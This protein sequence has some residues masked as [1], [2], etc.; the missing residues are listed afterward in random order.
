M[1]FNVHPEELENTELKA[2]A[3]FVPFPLKE[4]LERLCNFKS[5]ADLE[6]V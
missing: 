3:I 5:T 2:M 4:A 1:S 6:A